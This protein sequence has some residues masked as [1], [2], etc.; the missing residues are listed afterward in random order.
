MVIKIQ[1]QE[2]G[3]IPTERVVT[4]ATTTGKEDVVVHTS[5]VSGDGIEVGFIKNQEDGRSVLVELPRETVT[6]RWRVW[7]PSTAVAR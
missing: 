7:V 6:G 4:I 3:P 1:G 2:E 5:Q